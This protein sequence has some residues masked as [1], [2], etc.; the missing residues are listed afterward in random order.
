MTSPHTPGLLAY[1][2]PLYPSKS[3]NPDVSAFISP[4]VVQSVPRRTLGTTFSV[5]R[6]ALPSWM[7]PMLLPPALEIVARIPLPILTPSQLKQALLTL[8]TPDALATLSSKA[9][10]LLVFNNATGL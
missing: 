3:F 2:L 6:V 5:A 10:N 7:S 8:A 4:P 9:P 1:F